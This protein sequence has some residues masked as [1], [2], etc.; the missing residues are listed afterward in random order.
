MSDI[1]SEDFEKGERI[2]SEVEIT[3]PESSSPIGDT[4]PSHEENVSGASQSDQVYLD[5]LDIGLEV[6]I[7]DNNSFFW[8][9]QPSKE[10]NNCRLLET[11]GCCIFSSFFLSS[12]FLQKVL[13]PLKLYELYEV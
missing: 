13:L 12:P 7:Y 1:S 8:S 2:S 6:E 10:K 5:V 11:R 3:E 9:P 4:E